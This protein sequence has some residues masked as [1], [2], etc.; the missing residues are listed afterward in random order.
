MRDTSQQGGVQARHL[1]LCLWSLAVFGRHRTELVEGLSGR[2]NNLDI[3][4]DME[5]E[6]KQ[7]V[8]EL[9][10]LSYSSLIS[11]NF[12]VSGCRYS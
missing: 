3:L 10:W 12:M 9:N 5:E 11:L 8:F 1:M 4:E 7:Q 6:Q 2:V